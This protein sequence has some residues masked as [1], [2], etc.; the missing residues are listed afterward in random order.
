[1]KVLH[2]S[3]RRIRSWFESGDVDDGLTSH[4][5]NCERCSEEIERIAGE[6]TSVEPA[7]AQLLAAPPDLGERMEA[8]IATSIQQRQDLQLLVEMFA[9]GG[10]TARLLLDPDGQQR[11]D[12]V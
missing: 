2:P 6:E 12:D 9:L 7:L 10:R 5:D 8:R 3:R 4:L 1:M 11:R